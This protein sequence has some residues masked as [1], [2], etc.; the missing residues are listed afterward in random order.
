MRAGRRAWLITSIGAI[1]IV[2]IDGGEWYL[3]GWVGNTT[4]CRCILVELGNFC[5]KKN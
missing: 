3:D 4:E 2:V 5:L 1:A